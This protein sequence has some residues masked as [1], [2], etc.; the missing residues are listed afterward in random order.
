MV[1]DQLLGFAHEPGA[2]PVIRNSQTPLLMQIYSGGVVAVFTV[3][4][5]MYWNA[6]RKRGELGL[7]ARQTLDARLNIIDN[8]GIAL[9][10]VLSVAIATFGGSLAAAAVAGPIYFLIGPFKFALGSYSPG[11]HAARPYGY[12]RYFAR[13][14]RHFASSPPHDEAI[15]A[16]SSP[17]RMRA[18]ADFEPSR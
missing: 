10:G 15:A 5:L 17:A 2:P 12:K 3:F 7:D 8:A 16:G 14:R 18:I 1:I 6:Y 13:V 9:I 4:A 11:L